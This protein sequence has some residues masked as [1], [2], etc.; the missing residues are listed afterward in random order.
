MVKNHFFGL[1]FLIILILFV[2]MACSSDGEPCSEL[3]PFCTREAKA[4]FSVNDKIV[5]IGD[6]FVFD[7]S[8]S[9]YDSI[10]WKIN[11]NEI[12]SCKNEEFCQQTISDAGTYKVEVKVT[13]EAVGQVLSILS[14]GATGGEST[15]DKATLEVIVTDNVLVAEGTGSSSSDSSSS[16]SGS[17]S[18]SSGSSSESL[19]NKIITV[20]ASKVKGDSVSDA[21]CDAGYSALITT[22]VIS[23]NTQYILSDGTLVAEVGSSGWFDFP[24]TNAVGGAKVWTGLNSSGNVSSNCNSW[25][26]NSKNDSGIEGDPGQTSSSAIDSGSAGCNGRKYVYCVEQ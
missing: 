10:Q 22:G 9:I 6:S 7:A 12:Y 21:L 14:V 3:D 16:S 4:T 24:F 2:L 19:P 8:E 11:G 26:S 18:S 25:S 23:S 15:S 13:V 20:S 17:S 5:L 1:I